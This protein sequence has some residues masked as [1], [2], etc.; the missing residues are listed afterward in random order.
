MDMENFQK[1]HMYA[2]NFNSII[3]LKCYGFGVPNSLI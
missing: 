2:D 3:V 1:L